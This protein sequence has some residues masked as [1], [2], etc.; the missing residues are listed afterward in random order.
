MKAHHKL[1]GIAICSGQAD[2]KI[3]LPCGQVVSGLM[4][5]EK[6]ADGNEVGAELSSA[7]FTP[8][9]FQCD[10]TKTISLEVKTSE[11]DH[12]VM[13]RYQKARNAYKIPID[14]V[15]RISDVPVSRHDIIII[16]Q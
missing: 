10:Y 2:E 16:L 3:T 8:D 14:F 12:L 1:P 6:D 7:F 9:F 13:D 15:S 11:S 4:C 5:C